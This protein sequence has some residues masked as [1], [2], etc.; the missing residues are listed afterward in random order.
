MVGVDGTK[1]TDRVTTL[2]DMW[3]LAVYPWRFSSG[4]VGHSKWRGNYKLKMVSKT[5]TAA[6]F[7]II[8][9]TAYLFGCRWNTVDVNVQVF[10]RNSDGYISKTELYQTMKELGV[11]LSIDDLNEMMTAADI[12]RDGRIDYAGDRVDWF[13]EGLT[14]HS[15]LNRSCQRCSS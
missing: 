9:T 12:N 15:T 4:T 6:I 13:N 10:D 5:M 3:N 2:D 8:T 14:S 7:V 1:H 11:R